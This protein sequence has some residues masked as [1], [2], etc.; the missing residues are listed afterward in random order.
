MTK[1][2]LATQLANELGMTQ[3]D[4]VSVL[5]IFLDEICRRLADGRR[6]ELR[7]FGVFEIKTRSSRVGR[8]PRT[9][10]QVAVPE[11]KVLTFKPG[12]RMKEVIANPPPITNP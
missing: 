6:L 5:E 11:R 7:D 4:V 3:K 1:R 10:E 12:K 8:N 2:E 9:G